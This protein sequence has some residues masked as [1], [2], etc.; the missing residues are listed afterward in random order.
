MSVVI[1]ESRPDLA[2]GRVGAYEALKSGVKT[3][4]CTDAAV[5][6]VISQ[7]M[8]DAVF[9]DAIKVAGNGDVA[10]NTGT[11]PLA[12]LCKQNDI[13][14]YVICGLANVDVSSPNDMAFVDEEK[15]A[16][17]MRQVG[18]GRSAL[19]VVAK[20]AALINPTFDRTACSLVSA[21]I[22]EEGVALP[23]DRGKFVDS[24]REKLSVRTA[25][26]SPPPFLSGCPGAA[27][28][29]GAP[30]LPRRDGT[31]AGGLLC[32]DCSV[33]AER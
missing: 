10:G 28:A 18:A 24:L 25:P 23:D 16:G 32:A 31:E 30:A 11:Y 29:A 7:R 17:L 15:S 2:G 3:T 8:V 26:S 13:P 20:G 21:I 4:V 14:F 33:E 6:H 12:L 22:T 1:A 19:P 27:S 9:V 5:G